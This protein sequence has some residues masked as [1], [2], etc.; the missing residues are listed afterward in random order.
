MRMSIVSSGSQAEVRNRY[1][2][3]EV[4]RVILVVLAFVLGAYVLW[5]I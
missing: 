4:A 3:G 1:P 5:R 2:P